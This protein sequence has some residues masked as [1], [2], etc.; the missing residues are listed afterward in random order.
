MVVDDADSDI[1]QVVRSDDLLSST[2][3][4]AYLATTLDLPIPTYAHVPLVLNTFGT[5]LA[6]RDG[7]VTLASLTSI[8]ISADRVR[9]QLA[10]SLGLGDGTET[11]EPTTL[12][13]RFDP[14][15]IPAGPWILDPVD[16]L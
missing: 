7:A 11:P 9:A 8:G 14:A 3:R 15:R 13:E 12:L 4:Q 16:L 10:G 1:D 5:R 2:P 6:K